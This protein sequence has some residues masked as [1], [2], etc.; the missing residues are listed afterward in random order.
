MAK[1]FR[2]YVP[3]QTFLLPPALQD[4][5]PEDHLARFISDVVDSLDLSE[6]EDAYTEE[7]G[8]PPYHPAMMIKVLLYGYCTGTHSSRR[9]AAMTLD[10]VAAGTWRPGMSDFRR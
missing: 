1:K 5:I 6:I 8:Y 10:S 4:W 7:R 9:L 2:P 3:E